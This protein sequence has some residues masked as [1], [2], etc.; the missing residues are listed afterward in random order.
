MESTGTSQANRKHHSVH[1]ASRRFNLASV[2]T[3]G[4]ILLP[5]NA[6]G[7]MKMTLFEVVDSDMG[8]NIILGRPRIHEI[9]VVTSTYHQLLKFPTLE[10][11]K[12]IKG[13]QPT[14]R[15]MN[16][17]SVSSSK[18]DHLTHLQE[19]FDILRKHNMKLN[20]KKCAFG[21]SSGKFLG[22]LVSQ[23]GIE[24]NPNKIKA[25][26]DI[27]NQLSNAKEVQRL[28]GRLTALSRYISRSLEKCH[29]FF[30]LLK[31]K[32]N[33]EWT[34]KCRHA[35][36][37]LKRYLS[38]PPL[39]SKPEEGKKLLIYLAVSE[40]AVS[41]VLVHEDEG[42]QS[43]KEIAYDNG[44]QFIAAK[45]AKFLED[46]K[47]KRITYSPYH[48][49]ANGQVESTNKLIIQNLKKRLETAKC[50][51]P[52]ELP[53]VLWA[54]RTTT[55]SS[56]GETPFSLVYEAE[57]LIPVEVGEPTLRYFRVDEEANN[58]ALL[59]RLELLDERRDLAYIRMAA[60]KQRTKRYYNRRA[61]L[62]YFKVGD[63]VLRK[64]T[65][66][67]QVLNV[68]KLGPTWEGPYRVSAVI[69]KGSYELK[70]HDGVKLSSY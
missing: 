31:K 48:P 42:M 27:P 54:Y 28:T 51:W 24:V 11:V 3:R 17:I 14:T 5:T 40:V 21:V 41:A 63:L 43:P 26:E 4:E 67:T 23:R 25:I 69:G 32:N 19:T 18:G 60:Q 29:H 2:T 59:V 64:V 66:N 47:I 58:E 20:L 57:A 13:D 70:N 44:P 68:R 34:P 49:S 9:K 16:A 56:M 35:L 22:F 61:N 46:L 7:V 36:K 39:L 12:K 52:E 50:K 37:D 62:R 10:G 15:N 30:S 55:K 53:G 65:Q 45:L 1:K 33:F 8:Y 38:S 6:E